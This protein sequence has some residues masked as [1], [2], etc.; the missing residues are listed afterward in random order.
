M[1][2]GKVKVLFSKVLKLPV[3]VNPMAGVF[4]APWLISENSLYARVVEDSHEGPK[5]QRN[6][7]KYKTVEPRDLYSNRR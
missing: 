3:F 5:T 6:T 7:K 1:Q 2:Q 4:E